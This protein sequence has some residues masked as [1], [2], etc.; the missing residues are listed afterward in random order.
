MPAMTASPPGCDMRLFCRS[1]MPGRTMTSTPMKPTTIAPQRRTPT[2]SF[3]KIIDPMVAKSGNV[4]EIAVTS[5]IG[6]M[7]TAV[8]HR[9]MAAVAEAPR[10]I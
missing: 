3:R 5:A 2:C 4:K 1:I 10:R 9:S 7:V 6:S 8:I